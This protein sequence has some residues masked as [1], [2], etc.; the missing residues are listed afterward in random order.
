MIN[1]E[2][3]WKAAHALR[4][5]TNA[6]EYKDFILPLI[7]YK[8]LSLKIQGTLTGNLSDAGVVYTYREACEAADCGTEPAKAILGRTVNNLG[9]YIRPDD[10]YCEIVKKSEEG[11]YSYINLESAFFR[12][13]E[14]LEQV[15]G[16]DYFSDLLKISRINDRV[17]QEL[18]KVV[19]EFDLHP[20]EDDL[21]SEY[22]KLINLFASTSGR[23]DGEY[24]TPD[25][26]CELIAGIISTHFDE[27]ESLSDPACGSGA[28]LMKICRNVNVKE[29]YGN[30]VNSSAIKMVKLNTILNDLDYRKT[31]Y[32]LKDTL[33]DTSENIYQV[34]VSNPPFSLR[35]K[36]VT[37]KK[38]PIPAPAVYADLAFVEH[39]VYHM[40]EMAVCIL[41]VGV[42][43]RKGQE[44]KIREWLMAQNLVDTVMLLAGNFFYNTA[45]P[46]AV[47][48]LKKNRVDKKILFIDGSDIFTKERGCAYLSEMQVNSLLKIYRERIESEISVLRER[49]EVIEGNLYIRVIHK[50]KH[51]YLDYREL[52]A[53]IYEKMH[54]VDRLERLIR[55]EV[56]KHGEN[57]HVG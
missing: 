31:E 39:M 42:L 2:T 5:Y 19:D 56:E 40:G 6:N 3:I 35:W 7:F 8:Y 22:M 44:K 41:P 9:Y 52:S 17:L 47:I 13:T 33:L 57:L 38:Y 11:N 55:Q 27:I 24:Y 10:L 14:S 4:G 1:M 50:E 15:T 54:N 48:V 18:I 36:P 30:D 53:R 32:L 25:C 45:T 49:D 12:L 29:I 51:D 34:Q 16:S 46:V 23:K 20:G 28:L 43:Y 37:N 21:G 26:I